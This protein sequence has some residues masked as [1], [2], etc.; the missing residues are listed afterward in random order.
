MSNFFKWA[1]K[2]K[3]LAQN[4]KILSLIAFL[5]LATSLFFVYQY[6]SDKTTVTKY[7]LTKV[8]KGTIVSS[9]SS[10][11]SVSALNQIDIKANTSG[12][13][14]YMAVKE[15]QSVSAGQFLAQL[16]TTDA[17][18]AIRTAEQNLASAKISLEKLLGDSSLDVPKNKQ[19]AEDNLLQD[20]DDGFNAVSNAFL[21]IPSIISGLNTILFGND[22]SKTSQNLD[23]YTNM[24]LSYDI[25]VTIYRD[26]A[27]NDYQTAYAAYQKSFSDYKIS[28]R[29]SDKDTIEKLINET[30]QTAKKISD[31][32]KSAN[33]L[34]QFYKDKISANGGVS[35]N[36][37]DTHISSLNSYTSQINS[38][39]S[40]LFGAQ[41]TIKNDK[42]ALSDADLDAQSQELSLQK[43]EDALAEAKANLND[44]YVYAPFSGVIAIMNARVGDTAPSTVATIVTKTLTAEISFGETDIARIK[45][46]QK[47]TLTFD[48]VSD[49]TI[50][51]KVSEIDTIGTSSQGVVS[52]NVKVVMDLQDERIKPG[53]STTATIITD[54]KTDALYVPNSAL[55]TQQGERYVL[56]VSETVA[57]ADIQNSS[58]VS[59]AGTPLRQTVETGLS[60]DSSTEIISGLNEGDIIVSGTVS[61]A[62]ITKTSTSSSKSSAGGGP[63]GGMGIPGL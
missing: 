42:I 14:V 57:D 23:A 49:L 2:A 58:G 21:T 35:S 15:G 33:N 3:L 4:H 24:I 20:Y 56:K 19:E 53:M 50:T 48:A 13:V 9:L 27:Y 18:K 61:S 52:Y 29:Y 25:N 6:F 59:L 41:S 7:V 39:L 55:K 34:V 10:S 22:F 44:C 54:T 30:Y 60:D 12:N 17:K 63:G 47:S 38:S 28:S 32:V 43:A 31:A 5:A 40:S 26:G 37:A 45:I 16:D 1:G 46:G 62:S 8:E 51:G 11:G 36:V